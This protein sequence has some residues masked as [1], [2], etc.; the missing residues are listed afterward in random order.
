MTERM[1]QSPFSNRYAS[2]EMA[3]LFSPHFK[4][5]TWRKLWIALAKAQKELGLSIT[6]K[7]IQEMEA[8]AE[9]AEYFQ[10]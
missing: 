7:Q 1:Y 10:Q 4:Y 8:A 3:Y 6:A 9:R 5:A 2:E